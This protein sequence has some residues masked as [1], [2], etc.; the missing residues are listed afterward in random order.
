MEELSELMLPYKNKEPE[1]SVAVTEE[2]AE[3]SVVET[4]EVSAEVVEA[5]EA[6][7]VEVSAE[8]VVVETVEVLEAEAEE[9]FTNNKHLGGGRG[10]VLLDDN[11]KAAKKGTIAGF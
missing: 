2:V 3:D 11:D 4:E 8:E 6:E 7:T 1:D 10:G 5:S 9:V